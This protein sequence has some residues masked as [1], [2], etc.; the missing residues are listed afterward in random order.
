MKPALGLLVL[1]PALAL[2]QNNLKSGQQVPDFSLFRTDEQQVFKK[3]MMNEGDF[4]IYFVNVSDPL[5]DQATRFLVRQLGKYGSMKTK[6]KAVLNSGPITADKWT[7]SNDPNM[8]V[9]VDP[10]NRLARLFGIKSAPAVVLVSKEGRALKTWQGW[11]GA[12]VKDLNRW[13]AK[14]N[15][16]S[17][18]GLGTARFTN[19]TR[20][21]R[22]FANT[23]SPR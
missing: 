10:T 15:G 12:G 8:D 14:M 7:L 20:F 5:S 17:P 16:E 4:F 9:F 2:G 23:S 13:I 22:P 11:S 18:K 3:D 21:G 1:L 6:W 19:A